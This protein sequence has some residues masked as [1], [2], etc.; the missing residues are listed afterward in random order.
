MLRSLNIYFGSQERGLNSGSEISW[1]LWNIQ[2]A[3]PELPA[4]GSW[5][6]LDAP[7]PY[8]YAL[9]RSHCPKVGIQSFPVFCMI[10]AFSA[11]LP[12]EYFTS[13]LW[14]PTDTQSTLCLSHLHQNLITLLLV[15]VNSHLSLFLLEV[16][17]VW[18]SEM[19]L[20]FGVKDALTGL[21]STNCSSFISY[22]HTHPHIIIYYSPSQ[23]RMD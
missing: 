19:V 2:K 8:S 3:P 18:S 15:A 13:H 22:I 1:R 5:G 17:T 10:P 11:Q 23:G 16:V 9:P 21:W 12:T 7:L 4:A 20:R 6:I 14:I